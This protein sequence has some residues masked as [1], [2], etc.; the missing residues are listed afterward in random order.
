M[1]SVMQY[2]TQ[3]YADGLH[4]LEDDIEFSSWKVLGT[5]LIIASRQVDH[6]NEK[7]TQVI[8]MN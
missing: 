1:V 8:Y 6:Y 2:E 5:S 4:E 7:A 3:S